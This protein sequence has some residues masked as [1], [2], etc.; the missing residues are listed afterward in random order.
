MP[1]NSLLSLQP[2]PAGC[3]SCYW[4]YHLQQNCSLLALCVWRLLQP[5]PGPKQLSPV[6]QQPTGCLAHCACPLL[7]LQAAEWPPLLLLPLAEL[8][9][10][11]C[12]AQLLNVQDHLKQF[13]HTL[14]SA[15][16]PAPQSPAPAQLIWA[17]QCKFSP[18][19]HRISR[20]PI[21]TCLPRYPGLSIPE[22]VR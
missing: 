4:C 5:L 9:W 20:L 21:A 22:S 6:H 8:L 1:S 19:V 7:P 2:P 14:S 3:A 10:A 12:P 15:E 16:L 11:L 17:V 18:S 13:Q